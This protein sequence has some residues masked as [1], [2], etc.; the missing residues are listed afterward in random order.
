MGGGEEGFRHLLGIM[1]PFLVLKE[2]RVLLGLAHRGFGAWSREH[3]GLK[4]MPVNRHLRQKYQWADL[5]K[6]ADLI[7]P[8]LQ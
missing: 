8:H 7:F 2:E 5:N 4:R 6:V 3:S 1:F